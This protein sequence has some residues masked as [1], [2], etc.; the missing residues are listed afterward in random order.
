MA[1]EEAMG[2]AEEAPMDE[3]AVTGADGEASMDVAVEDSDHTVLFTVCK[4]PDGTYRL[5]QGDEDDA[6]AG[7]DATDD[8]VGTEDE[9]TGKVYDSPGALLKAILDILNEDGAAAGE[10]G[11]SEDQFQAGFGADGGVPTGAA[12]GVPLQQ[13][14]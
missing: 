2:V 14:Y 10:E 6:D 4:E 7:G 9:D 5:I 11:S 8:A 1:L 12:E 13:K 3:D